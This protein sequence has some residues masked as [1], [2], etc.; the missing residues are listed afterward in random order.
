MPG[1]GT[2]T[3]PLTMR[4]ARPAAVAETALVTVADI[5]LLTDTLCVQEDRVVDRVNTVSWG[6]MKLQLPPSP[7]RA[8]YVKAR[9]RVHEYPDGVLAV[10]HGP[11]CIARYNAHGEEVPSCA[12]VTPC[13]PPSRTL[14]AASG[15]GLRGPSLTAAARG[16]TGRGQVGTKKR[17]S[18]RTKKLTLKKPKQVTP[19]SL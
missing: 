6:R 4:F 15:G 3:C 13:S 5:T 16:I 19:A 17:P 1:S 12:S 9:V 11:R 2:S 10:F 14:R 18:G 7:L 8:H